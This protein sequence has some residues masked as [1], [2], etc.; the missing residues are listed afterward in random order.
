MTLSA[1]NTLTFTTVTTV[2]TV[3]V[4]SKTLV[5]AWDDGV[6]LNVQV[7]AGPVASVPRPVVSAGTAQFTEG[8]DNVAAAVGLVYFSGNFYSMIYR[9]GA[10]AT[11]QDLANISAYNRAKAGI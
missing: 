6:N 1:G 8:T 4:G 3:D 2:A 5:K 7:N 9:T 10:P 11:A